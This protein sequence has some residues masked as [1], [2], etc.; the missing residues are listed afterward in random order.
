[1]SL[2]LWGAGWWEEM[3]GDKHTAHQH[4][5]RVGK[6]KCQDMAD[7]DILTPVCYKVAMLE[8]G[9]AGHSGAN[10]TDVLIKH[11]HLDTAIRSYRSGLE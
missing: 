8:M 9:A 7:V 10:M 1:M 5:G 2:S 3:T 6:R 4:V 11:R